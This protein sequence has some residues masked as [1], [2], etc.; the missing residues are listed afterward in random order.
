MIEQ[1]KEAADQFKKPVIACLGLAFKAD[2]DDLR[3]SPAMDIVQQLAA[4]QVGEVL[5]VEPHIRALPSIL[6]NNNVTMV[7][8][9][10][11]LSRANIIVILVDHKL[12]KEVDK[13]QYAKKVVIDTRGVA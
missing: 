10:Q 8:F 3:E 7:S 1:V 11:A 13:T 12:F 9:E 2:I 6:V 5:A 4:D